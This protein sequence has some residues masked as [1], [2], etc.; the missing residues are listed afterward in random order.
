MIFAGA[1]FARLAMH[2]GLIDEY[3]LLTIPVLFE[4]VA[5]QFGDARLDGAEADRTPED[6]HG[7]GPDPV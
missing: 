2:T 3:W 7:S 5:R 1:D 6:G 4:G